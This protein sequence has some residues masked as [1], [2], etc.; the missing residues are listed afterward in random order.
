MARHRSKGHAER[1]VWPNV[2]DGVMRMSP[3][4]MAALFAGLDWRLFGRSARGARWRR[5]ARREAPKATAPAGR[6][7]GLGLHVGSWMPLLS[8]GRTRG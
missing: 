4:R 5:G 3:A 8:P 2:R 7:G 6:N 1:F